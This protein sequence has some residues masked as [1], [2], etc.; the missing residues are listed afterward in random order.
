MD[1][2]EKRKNSRRSVYDEVNRKLCQIRDEQLQGEDAEAK[3]V[4]DTVFSDCMKKDANG[5][6]YD[7]SHPLCCA[8]YEAYR[9]LHKHLGSMTEDYEDMMQSVYTWILDD[10]ILIGAQTE[11]LINRISNYITY[12]GKKT[13]PKTA[14]KNGIFA[15]RKLTP[16][17]K[18]YMFARMRV[19]WKKWH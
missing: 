17:G 11:N 1:V 18:K 12:D 7:L 10:K 5:S 3:F 16:D 19:P 2:A 4:L 15:I 8:V 9:R 13:N 6:L 14:K